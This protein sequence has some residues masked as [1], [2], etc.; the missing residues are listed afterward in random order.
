M[1]RPPRDRQQVFD[2]L[3]MR[4]QGSP[5]R[6][7]P[8]R[9]SLWETAYTLFRRWQIDGTWARVL[10]KLRADAAGRLV[11]EMSVDSTICRARQYAA[12]ATNRRAADPGRAGPLPAAGGLA[13]WRPGGRA[14]RARAWPLT[15]RPHRQE[16][17]GCRHL[18]SRPGAVVTAGDSGPMPRCS[19]TSWTASVFRGSVA[20]IGLRG[21]VHVVD[22]DACPGR[23][24]RQCP[25]APQARAGA[26]D[27]GGTALQADAGTQLPSSVLRTD[28]LAPKL[29]A[30][31]PRADE[32]PV[33]AGQF[34]APGAGAGHAR[35]ARILVLWT[36]CSCCDNSCLTVA[37]ERAEGRACHRPP[38]PVEGDSE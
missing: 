31:R 29:A 26:G 30:A 33:E 16:S 5:W 24:E 28:S 6:D 23:R 27:D 3:V 11:W 32:H 18:L 2:G 21:R 19:A 22:H 20:D 4:S 12:G 38:D 13:A 1:G 36:H 14:G 34:D 37:P 7:M 25:A 10:K 17:P 8:E 35:R 9:Y 15:R